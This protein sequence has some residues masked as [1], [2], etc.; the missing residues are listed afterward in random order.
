MRQSSHVLHMESLCV[1]EFLVDINK[2]HHTYGW[3]MAHIR[4]CH[5]THM[6]ASCHTY[7]I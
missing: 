5:S 1:A 2:T 4:M 6:N 3:V 7:D